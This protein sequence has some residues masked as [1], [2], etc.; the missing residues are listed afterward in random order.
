MKNGMSLCWWDLGLRVEIFLGRKKT[1]MR[2]LLFALK[3]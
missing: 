3:K 1:Q 2:L